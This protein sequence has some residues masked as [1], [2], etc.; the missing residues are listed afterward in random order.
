MKTPNKQIKLRKIKFPNHKAI[1]MEVEFRN[2][3]KM[4]ILHINFAFGYFNGPK[5]ISLITSLEANSVHGKLQF[6]STDQ[7][8]S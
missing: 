5:Y 2:K 1:L 6:H 8:E 4:A 3:Q 7:N